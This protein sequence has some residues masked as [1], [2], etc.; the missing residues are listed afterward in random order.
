MC[1][2]HHIIWLLMLGDE[3][4]LRVAAEGKNVLEFWYLVGF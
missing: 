4:G 2:H 3:E 1:D